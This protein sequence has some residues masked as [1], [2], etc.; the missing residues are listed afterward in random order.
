MSKKEKIDLFLGKWVSRKLTAFL[1][2]SIALFAGSLESADWTI[3][4]TVYIGAQAATDIVEKL[5]KAKNGV[6]E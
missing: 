3:V 6:T 5:F 1:I 2:A 4:T